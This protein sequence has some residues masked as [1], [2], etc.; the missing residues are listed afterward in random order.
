MTYH[1]M[2]CIVQGRA[3]AP[4]GSDFH[5]GLQVEIVAE[6]IEESSR[7]QGRLI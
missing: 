7:N 2:E 5:E 4:E 6:A 3:V 1:L